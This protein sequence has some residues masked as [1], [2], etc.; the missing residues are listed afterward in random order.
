MAT[1]RVRAKVKR[2]GLIKADVHRILPTKMHERNKP[3][4]E[5]TH[6]YL[7][8]F[9]L[10]LKQQQLTHVKV[11]A[12][13]RIEYHRRS[14]PQRTRTD[15]HIHTYIHTDTHS[16]HVQGSRD[17]AAVL[18]TP[19]ASIRRT[20]MI[21][22]V[23]SLPLDSVT[24]WALHCLFLPCLHWL[25]DWQVEHRGHW[26]PGGLQAWTRSSEWEFSSHF[27]SLVH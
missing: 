23:E 19:N 26:G 9:S 8:F 21:N 6:K 2:S 10:S 7:L 4:R 15:A 11:T 25:T 22:P 12:Q 24:C 5:R 20:V 27:S 13:L 18:I 1:A 17:S 16:T 14:R 3:R